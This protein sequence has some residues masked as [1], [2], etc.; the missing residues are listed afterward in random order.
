ME[1]KFIKMMNLIKLKLIDK[2]SKNP[3]S[4][5]VEF[6]GCL[7]SFSD[8]KDVVIKGYVSN[9][10]IKEA[11]NKHVKD[12]D[13]TK[14][15]FEKIGTGVRDW[16]EFGNLVRDHYPNIEAVF[17][18]QNFGSRNYEEAKLDFL[19]VEDYESAEYKY[20]TVEYEDEVYT[21]KKIFTCDLEFGL[22]IEYDNKLVLIAYD[23]SEY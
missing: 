14:L 6:Y 4:E 3:K 7:D 11:L 15:Y 10:D 5:I 13:V 20:E 21:I 12:E 9:Y 8:G 23:M 18:T 1:I 2:Y 17:L 19:V 16:K 22:E